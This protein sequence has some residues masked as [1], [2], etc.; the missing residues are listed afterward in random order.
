[1]TPTLR[2]DFRER[3][4]IALNYIDTALSIVLMFPAYRGFGWFT[5]EVGCPA[6]L[7]R[8]TSRRRSSASLLAVVRVIPDEFRAQLRAAVEQLVRADAEPH[9]A[10]H[11]RRHGDVEQLDAVCRQVIDRHENRRCTEVVTQPP[12]LVWLKAPRDCAHHA[13][14][15]E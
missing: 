10:P 2:E 8:A 14:V 3:Q 4:I 5:P 9:D 12:R 6:E 13:P 7:K 11:C 15:S 1:M